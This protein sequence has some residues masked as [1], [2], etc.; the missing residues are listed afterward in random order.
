LDHDQCTEADAA[1]CNT[2]SCVPCT[3]AAHCA[4]VT[5]ATLCESGTC[6]E[7]TVTNE[8]ACSGTQT[9]D[10]LTNTC[11]DVEAGTVLNCNACTNDLQCETD[12]RC[13]QMDFDGNPHG[14]YCLRDSPAPSCSRPFLIPMS[15]PSLN[16]APATNYCSIEED[17]ATCEAVLALIADWHCSGTDGMCGPLNQ[18]EVAVPGA[19]CRQIPGGDRC[20][21]ECDATPQ[22]PSGAPQNTCGT[23]TNIPPGWCGG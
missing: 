23:G 4:G 8:S 14:Y 7:C 17:L 15:K 6:V 12:H 21:Y 1:R 18:P 16:G 11:V 9:C 2:G 3:D 22:C 13:I 5:D 20:T 19:I 10:L